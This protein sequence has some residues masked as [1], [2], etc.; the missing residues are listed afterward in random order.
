MIRLVHR[1]DWAEKVQW[2]FTGEG[3]NS[4]T[5]L[6][7][8]SRS[9]GF[10]PHSKNMETVVSRLIGHSKLPVDV[11]WSVDHCLSIHVSPVMNSQLVKGLPCLPLIDTGIGSSLL[12]TPS[13]ISGSQSKLLDWIFNF[14]N[15]ILT[16]CNLG[17]IFWADWETEDVT[18]VI[19][20]R[21]S[22]FL[23]Q[24]WYIIS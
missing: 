8:L 6:L 12:V 1:G 14:I 11:T 23:F 3:I 10:F 13:R 9:S 2:K 17:I 16:S 5:N 20:V 24:K 19:W 22:N 15:S 21:T 18:K 7:V 4:F